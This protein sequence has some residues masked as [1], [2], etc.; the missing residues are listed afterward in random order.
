MKI[1]FKDL[2]NVADEKRYLIDID[3]YQV[4]QNVF[5]K[6]LEN[7]KGDL[8]FYYDI[9][10]DLRIS[11]QLSGNMICPCAVS[12]EDV[13]VPFQIEE[14]DKVVTDQKEEGFF[15]QQEEEIEKIVL[16]IILPEVPIKV[17]K[18][19]KIEYSRGDG[20]SFVSEE[21]YESDKKKEIDPRLQKLREYRFEEDD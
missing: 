2:M 17:V 15:M 19:E 21:A 5:L 1:F 16:R 4:E 7:V 11:Y 13:E 12:L 18:K 8:I 9:L 14:D 6:R 3:S 10:D 20:W